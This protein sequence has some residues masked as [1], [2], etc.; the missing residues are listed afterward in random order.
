MII[1]PLP[2][3]V[4]TFR[5]LALACVLTHAAFAQEAPVPVPAPALD[6][7]ADAP[8]PAPKPELAHA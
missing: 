3:A 2:S 7:E 8:A 4:K 6:A 1:L 5:L